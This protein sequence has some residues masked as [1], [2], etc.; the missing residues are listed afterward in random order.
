MSKKAK[1]EFADVLGEIEREAK[2]LLLKPIANPNR[3]LLLFEDFAD[4]NAELKHKNPKNSSGLTWA[5]EIFAGLV[6]RGYSKLEAYRLSHPACKTENLNTVYPKASRLAK[7]GKVE[8]RIDAIRKQLAE[9]ALMC[10]TEF[11]Q[12][13]TAIAREGG[14][15]SFDALVKIGQIH[16]VFKP[17]K[18]M[19]SIGPS[20]VVQT[21]DYSKVA[22]TC[23]KEAGADGKKSGEEEK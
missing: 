19:V 2:E 20:V 1:K 18:E 12:R 21:V 15:D 3:Q 8:A 14:K 16:G 10:P 17:E 11:F 13:L 5:Q 6:A 22:Q 23:C 7:L 9:R 4:A